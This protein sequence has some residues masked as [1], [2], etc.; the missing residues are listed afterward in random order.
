MA[1]VVTCL[2]QPSSYRDNR[3]E[4]DR[5]TER[6]LLAQSST[7][8]VGNLSFYTTEAQM[9]ELFS[10]CAR[11]DEGGGIKRI[12]MGLDRHQKILPTFRSNPGYKEGRQFGR[13]KSG[14]QVRDEFRQEY[15]SG[16]GG[17]GHQRLEEEKR[18]QEQERLRSQIQFDTYAAVGGLGMAGADV[19]RGEGAGAD[20]QKRGRSEDE[21]IERREDEKRLRGERDDE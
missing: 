4:I 5:E 13:G 1:Q 9:Y 7:L 21:D 16:R 19:P 10:T 8:Y 6:R 18:R 2:D 11:P 14:G 20:R 15:D 12:I 3:S 17:W